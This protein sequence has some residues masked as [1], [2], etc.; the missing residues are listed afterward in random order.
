M[1]DKSTTQGQEKKKTK[2][3]FLALLV[4]GLRFY[5]KA[6]STSEI[7]H[8]IDCAVKIQG[9]VYEQGFKALEI[10]N[11]VT[12]IILKLP[13][14]LIIVTSVYFKLIHGGYLENEIKKIKNG[15]KYLFTEY[16]WY[17]F[18]S[19][20]VLDL[21]LPTDGFFENILSALIVIHV[22]MA[23]NYLAIKFVTKKHPLIAESEKLKNIFIK[24]GWAEE[25]SKHFLITRAGI[26]AEIPKTSSK[27]VISDTVLWRDLD[28]DPKEPEECP[29][30]RKVI[31]IGN[32]FKLKKVA[33][34]LVKDK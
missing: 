18:N 14:L 7:N 19:D 3:P 33:F 15:F 27:T 22:I 31:F 11:R 6:F 4:M 16:N 30:D 13:A 9:I 34:E 21:V 20:E 1:S 32:G 25:D 26:L 10:K 17:E 23:I 8:I 28:R 5:R 29:H 12:A 2:N 24:K